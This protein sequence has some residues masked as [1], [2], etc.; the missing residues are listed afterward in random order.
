M[1]AGCAPYALKFI[2]LLLCSP[3]RPVRV[4]TSDFL[5]VSL[6][7]YGKDIFNGS[8]SDAEERVERCSTLIQETDW[9]DSV[10]KL[11]DIRGQICLLLNIEPPVRREVEA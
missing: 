2:V 9:S 7:T 3:M 10:S 1:L 5:Q 6:I 4:S 8:V 11:K